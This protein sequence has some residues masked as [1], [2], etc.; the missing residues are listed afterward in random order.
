MPDNFTHQRRASGWER[1]NS[2]S[3]ILVKR[4]PL[5]GKG[6]SGIIINNVQY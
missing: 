3:P 6:L 1:V 4:E 5:G 2:F